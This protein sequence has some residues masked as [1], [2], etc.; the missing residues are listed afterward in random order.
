MWML[1]PY[2]RDATVAK[3]ALEQNETNFEA[4]VEI[5]IGRK[6]SHILLIKQ[7]YQKR[8]RRQLDQDIINLEPLHPYQKILLALS[9]SHKAHHADISQHIAKCDARRLYETGE[10]SRG[11]IEEVVVLEILS[12][13]SI[14]QMKLTL[15]SYK[16][17]YGYDYRKSI[18]RGNYG[19]FEKAL[20]MVVKCICDPPHYYAK[21][22]HTSIK[23]VKSHKATLVQVL[24]S[25]IKI[26][27]DEIQRVFK[28]KYGKDFRDVINESIPCGDNRDFL[29]SLT[30]RT[31]STT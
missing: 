19:E 30:T 5:F 9:T 7:A 18:K 29:V 24:V 22:L 6:S 15:S 14:P 2:E 13:R 26:D 10:G 17:I 16:H 25:R 4:L 23:G 31:S 12:K 27:M 11:A 20:K 21:A 8:F 28:K 3:E 1:D